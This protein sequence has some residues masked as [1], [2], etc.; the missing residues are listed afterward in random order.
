M[1]K[2]HQIHRLEI[3]ANER[4]KSNIDFGFGKKQAVPK[5][6]IP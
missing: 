3:A 5:K 1:K 4:I 2:V 6:L